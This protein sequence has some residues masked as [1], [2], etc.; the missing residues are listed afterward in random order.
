MRYSGWGAAAGCL[1][2]AAVLAG[3]PVEV[4]TIRINTDFVHHLEGPGSPL[5]LAEMVLQGE[6]QV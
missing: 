2:P 5:D 3:V 6:E 4:V 1:I